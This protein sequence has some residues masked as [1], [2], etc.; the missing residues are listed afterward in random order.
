MT[1]IKKYKNLDTLTND[2]ISSQSEPDLKISTDDNCVSIL[3]RIR[4]CATPALNDFR[5]QANYTEMLFIKEE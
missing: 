5:K 1:Y 2:P 4:E 3:C